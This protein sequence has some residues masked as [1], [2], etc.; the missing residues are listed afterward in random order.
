MGIK[1]NYVWKKCDGCGNKMKRA[2]SY[3]NKLLCWKCYSKHIRRM[4]TN[5]N[6]T[7]E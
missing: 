5:Y 1:N 3:K 2:R 4:P 6:R 7:L